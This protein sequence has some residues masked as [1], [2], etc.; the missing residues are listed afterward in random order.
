LDTD[1][2][3]I[4]KSSIVFGDL[5][6]NGQ[7]AAALVMDNSGS[8]SGIFKSLIA[9]WNENGTLKNSKEKN[10]GDR[11]V[12]KSIAIKNRVVIVNMLTQGPFD[13]MCC[14]TQRKILRLAL[15]ENRF[16]D[17]R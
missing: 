17:I 10:L 11:I 9:V 3:A 5:S 12:V 2:Y 14:P 6:G 8:G 13:G 4:D 15:E 7:P 16:V 1:V